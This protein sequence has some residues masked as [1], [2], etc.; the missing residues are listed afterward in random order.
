MKEN[1]TYED[2]MKELEKVVK[3]LESNELTLD[4]SIKKFEMG[5]ELSRHCSKLLE[6]AEKKILLLVES[7]EENKELKEIELQEE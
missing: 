2:S 3:D 5:M 1:M 4:E 7:E 6:S